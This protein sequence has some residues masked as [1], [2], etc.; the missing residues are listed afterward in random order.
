MIYIITIGTNNY[1][2]GVHLAELVMARHPDGGTVCL[3]TGGAAAANP[4]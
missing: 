4:T 2:I 1:N 3:Q